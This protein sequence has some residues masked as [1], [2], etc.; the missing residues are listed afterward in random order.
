MKK[1][2]K[3]KTPNLVQ[4]PTGPTIYAPMKLPPMVTLHK[5]T[6]NS[7]LPARINQNIPA[8]P[9]VGNQAPARPLGSMTNTPNQVR[10]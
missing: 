5:Q 4:R 8:A 1:V 3:S 10:K 6:T 7:A 9:V 2:P